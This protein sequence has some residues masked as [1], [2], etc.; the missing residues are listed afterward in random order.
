M[1]VDKVLMGH[2]LFAMLPT[3]LMHRLS[4]VSAV[5]V[6]HAGEVV[7]EVNQPATHVYMLMNGQVQLRVPAEQG[8][9]SFI[10]SNIERGELF[11]LSPLLE[12]K[13]YT[14]AAHCLSETEL[15]AIEGEPFQELLRNNC[16]A[17]FAIMNRVAHIFF[18]RYIDVIKSLQGV[19]HQLS[20]IR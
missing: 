17:S 9:I 3:E 5:K 13:R 16:P 2:D 14:S 19:A 10:V 11:G 18:H 7:F 12:S 4:D 1:A 6:C 20:L 8:D 15:L